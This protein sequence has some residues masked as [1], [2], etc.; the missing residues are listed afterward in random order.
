MFFGSIGWQ[1]KKKT[2]KHSGSCK[3]DGVRGTEAER[4]GTDIGKER[5]TVA[6]KEV[7]TENANETGT[8]R[9]KEVGTE[10]SEEVGRWVKKEEIV[11]TIYTGSG[12]AETE[13]RPEIEGLMSAMK[14]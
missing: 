7:E 2:T 1:K 8:E 11:N 6:S 4:V 9:S 14:K 13:T 12:G 10:S 5:V 3:K